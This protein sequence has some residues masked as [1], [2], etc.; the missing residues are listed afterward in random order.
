MKIGSNGYTVRI[1]LGVALVLAG[2]LAQAVRCLSM[3]EV[4]SYILQTSLK[5][6]HGT[7]V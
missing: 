1:Q 4:L 6:R 3:H 7:N 5:K 2:E